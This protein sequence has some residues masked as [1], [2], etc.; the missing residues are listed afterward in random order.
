MEQVEKKQIVKVI[1]IGIA[2]IV[3][4]AVMESANK[5]LSD[6]NQ[7]QRNEPGESSKEV[8][9]ILNGAGFKDYPYQLEISEEKLTA[10]QAK[11]CF[12]E[13]EQEIGESFYQGEGG[14]NH[15]SERVSIQ[16]AYAQNM[17]KADWMF[18]ENLIMDDGTIDED[19]LKE[20]DDRQDG[21]LTTATVSLSCQDYEEEYQ[22][23][24]IVFPKALTEEEALLKQIDENLADQMEKAGEQAIV[25]PEKLGDKTIV[26][27]EANEHLVLKTII[28]EL[29]IAVL[30]C[31]ARRERQREALRQRKKSM[32]LEYSEIVSKMAILLGS[33]M[34]IK[35]AWSKIS[36]RYLIKR[37]KNQ[38]LNMPVYE[39]MLVTEREIDDGNS[40]RAA[41]QNFAERV[42]I[43]CYNRLMRLL[44]S[45]LERG[46][47]QIC[48]SLQQESEEA[49]EERKAVAK[50]MG[51]EAST[52][53]LAPM[54]IMMM[55]VI[56]IV[57]VPALL[58]FR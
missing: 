58:S 41:Y 14:L 6:E 38:G 22:F 2:F 42:N 11:S 23:S 47:R 31:A 48:D 30:Y 33:G 53:M 34:S 51:E 54:M 29:A 15:V 44:I 52:R 18:S 40:E 20:Y 25:L 9:L 24:F 7:I 4:A 28:F 5:E 3:L 27:Q 35:Q 17:V 57:I 26:W 37:E 50:K 16:E 1:I 55:I 46:S 12:E 39:E 36:A 56:A 19:R 8:S 43:M 10:S 21:I 45:S 49:F 32:E 13:A